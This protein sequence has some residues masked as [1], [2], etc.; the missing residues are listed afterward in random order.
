MVYS[1]MQGSASSSLLWLG[2]SLM[3]SIQAAVAAPG[4]A[5]IDNHYY[6]WNSPV[7]VDLTTM[8]ILATGINVTDCQREGG[9]AIQNAEFGATLG[10]DPTIFYF[11]GIE[12]QAYGSILVLNTPGA[13]LVCDQSVAGPAIFAHGFE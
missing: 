12:Y 6:E 3:A 9:G 5:L 8:T 1:R 7:E 10:S 2:L 4:Y 11:F 13:D